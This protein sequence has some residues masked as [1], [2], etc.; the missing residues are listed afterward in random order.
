[1]LHFPGLPVPLTPQQATVGPCPCWRL[2]N[3]HTLTSA[4]IDG[5]RLGGPG[6][7]PLGPGLC[8]MSAACEHECQVQE[9][10]TEEPG[11]EGNGRSDYVELSV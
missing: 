4:A 5:D 7:R 3:I 2:P 9:P 1:M 8:V 11:V 6:S 10:C